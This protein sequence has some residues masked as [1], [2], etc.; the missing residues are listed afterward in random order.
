MVL[1]NWATYQ[2]HSDFPDTK[3]GKAAMWMQ[4]AGQW[5]A[6]LLYNWSLFAPAIFPDRD[7]G[8]AALFQGNQ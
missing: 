8:D 2:E 6:F 4:V 5:V 1:T 7:F 3:A